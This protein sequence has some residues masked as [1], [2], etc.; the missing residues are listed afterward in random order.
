MREEYRNHARH[1]DFL[2]EDTLGKGLLMLLQDSMALVT[3]SHR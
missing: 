1:R 2:F 3:I